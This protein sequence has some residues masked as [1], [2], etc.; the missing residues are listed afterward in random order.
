M[1]LLSGISLY[2]VRL[3]GKQFT[4]SSDFPRGLSPKEGWK[5]LLNR[6]LN[7]AP[8]I[9]LGMDWTVPGTVQAAST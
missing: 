8:G 5:S 1:S 7:I 2:A 3:L 6:I 4:F 9:F